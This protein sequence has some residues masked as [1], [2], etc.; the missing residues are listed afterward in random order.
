MIKQYYFANVMKRSLSLI[1]C[2]MLV[3]SGCLGGNDV[4]DNEE[5]VEQPLDTDGDGFPDSEDA[6]DDNDLWSD[7]DELNCNSNSLLAT[8]MPTDTDNDGICDDLD[9]DK[10]GDGWTNLL[11]EAC[12]TDPVVA[13]NIPA[14]TDND[15][16]C[17]PLD[18]DG[19]GDTF[20]D[21]IEIQCGSDPLDSNN[22]PDDMD[23][24][25]V[26]DA[27]DNDMDGDGV[28]NDDD[29]APQDSGKTEGIGGC[30][31]LTALNYDES[32]EVDDD[33]CFTLEDAQTAME[34]AMAG[35]F[36]S[37]STSMGMRSTMIMNMTAG[38]SSLSIASLNE[39]GEVMMQ[40]TYV[41]DGTEYVEVNL[42]ISPEAEDFS[43]VLEQY[44][45]NGAYYVTDMEE[46]GWSHCEFDENVW[47][48]TD[49]LS[50][51]GHVYNSDSE[52]DR[53]HLY[54]CVNGETVLLS[55]V[56][57]GV[58]DCSD[59]TDEPDLQ[60]DGSEFQCEDGSVIEFYLANDGN[61]DCAD[62]S[63]E[64]NFIEE[65]TC[66]NGDEIFSFLVNDGFDDC[67]D[68]SDEP[69]YNMSAYETSVYSCENG[70]EILL[71]LVNDGNDDCADGTDE[72]PTGGE[73]EPLFS[74][75]CV[76]DEIDIS[77]SAVNDGFDDCSD[78]ADEPT[79]DDLQ[80]ETSEF[81]CY[82]FDPNAENELTIISLSQVN[83]GVVDCELRQDE[84]ELAGN[85]S[86]RWFGYDENMD[87]YT[88]E[89]FYFDEPFEIPWSW[90]NDGIDDCDDGSDEPMFDENGTEI[91]TITCDDG[92]E[93]PL[94]WANDGEDDCS[95]GED[96][97]TF[98]M[99][100]EY[101]CLNGMTIDFSWV[102]DGDDDCESGS[103]EPQY[104]LE[105]ISDFECE[106]G[107]IIPFS[108]VND[109]N[110]DCSNAE[111]E[112]DIQEVE[113]SSFECASG[114]YI[115]LSSV[116]DGAED[117]LGGDDEPSYDPITQNEVSTY[118]CLY[119]GE[120]V[121]LS[122]V[123]DGIDG[124]CA[125]GTDEPEFGF[126]DQN[127]MECADGSYTISLVYANDGYE[128]CMDGSDEAQ[129]ETPEDES[130]FLCADGSQITITEFNDGSVDCADGS[131]E[132][133]T[134]TCAD[135][136][137]EIYLLNVNDGGQDCNDGSDESVVE[138]M[139]E[140]YC[141]NSDGTI[142]PSQFNDGITDCASDWSTGWDEMEFEQMKD[143][144][145]GSDETGWM[146][147]S[148]FFST[149]DSYEMWMHTDENG[150]EMIGLNITKS[151]G[152]VMIAFFDA[153]SH[154]LMKVEETIYDD[155]FDSTEHMLLVTSAYDPTL[156]NALIVNSSLDTHAPP[157]ALVFYGEPHVIDDGSEFVCEEDGTT[158]A[159]S[160]VNDGHDD[161]S[162][163]SDEP[164]YDEEVYTCS[165]DGSEI[166]MSW[167]NDGEDDCNEGSDEPEYD[168]SGSE[169]S[170]FSCL[171]SGESIVL[172]YVNDGY[173][174]CQDETDE[175]EGYTYETSFFEC[176]DGEY[177]IDLS[178][179]NNGYEDCMD[180]SDE[181]ASGEGHGFGQYALI[182]T[183]IA[184]WT[185]G[186]GDDMLELV[187][188]MCESFE[189]V[190]SSNYDEYL[191]PSDCGDELARY[192]LDDIMNGE[193][194]GLGI[195]DLSEDL[196]LI[197]DDEFELEGWNTIRVSTPDGQYSDENPQV[198]LPAPGFGFAIVAMLCGAIIAGR[199]DD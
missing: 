4:I 33:S 6:D 108:Y 32:A 158:V 166:P 143:C 50:E 139:N 155:E 56:N 180:G 23:G 111:D 115:P 156:V 194:D 192:S 132:L 114:D 75:E 179:V 109:G 149:D 64:E 91:S 65:F 67:P 187:F 137:D 189:E 190:E 102:N 11:E 138:D 188:A 98:A 164:T 181:S 93:I 84:A 26:C 22:I 99:S 40:A 191:I 121:P 95:G 16:T 21:G 97:T 52:N 88:D 128:D 86:S 68:A 41:S 150:L 107:S 157:F 48:C 161:C 36:S 69:V 199:R 49:L 53:Y 30:T 89:C 43:P 141:Y 63:D 10:D 46:G 101:D 151:D 90:V 120:N 134:F 80:Q 105:E 42:Y 169:I 60:G 83:D 35:V 196:T 19:D 133:S 140:V 168:G 148:I 106:D 66:T 57:D 17:D 165:E 1:F 104:D 61:S 159:F 18:E 197:V 78:G 96:E 127:E 135:G 144:E 154:A 119:S 175:Q 103:D 71:S 186:S 110:D 123:N 5:P 152:S 79:Y 51:D 7:I 25:G 125:D 117:C 47:H 62:G 118:T 58:A 172:S 92:S 178:E 73:I 31:D 184:E 113:Y 174:D 77:L 85:M 82:N 126:E 24:D 147:T 129:Y 72:N 193:V 176:T 14:D 15:G 142:S 122:S 171:F 100:V 20:S 59:S 182:S 13:S 112:P 54:T 145:W 87:E 162:E 44:K 9:T 74:F 29:F 8:S 153:S 70:E 94:S 3:L 2:L 130:V 12:G 37:Q 55:E 160:L 27:M 131:D 81:E 195:S 167:V 163:G 76:V 38:Q 34:T 116:N 185:I 146:C 124:D 183:G 198:Q 173:A 136:S 39:D 170:S 28:D 45:V 177:E